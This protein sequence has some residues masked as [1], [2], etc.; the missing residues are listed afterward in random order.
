MIVPEA[1]T[2]DVPE[3]GQAAPFLLIT[4]DT[5]GDN[6]WSRPRVTGTRN[7]EFVP[8]FQELCERHHLRPTWLTNHEMISSAVFRTFAAD[9]IARDTAEIG[10]HLHAWDSPPLEP[11]TPDDRA[12]QP[13]LIEYPPETMRLKIRALTRELEEALGVK[14]VSHRAGRW[15]FD[16]RYAEML[17]EEGY[18]VDSS[19]T[20]RVSWTDTAGGLEGSGGSDY[21]AFPEDAYW[22]DLSDVSRAGS[23]ALLEVPMTILSLRSRAVRS[24]VDRL[25]HLDPTRHFVRRAANRLSPPL[26][27]LR[28]TGR[29]GLRLERVAR[30]VL[31]ER[32]RYA[33][34]MLHSS[35]LM[36]AGSPTFRDSRAIEQM[37][38][39][40]EQLFERIGQHFRP[41]TLSEFHDELVERRREE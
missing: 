5:E 30:R 26:D 7:A 3:T 4:I 23:S 34:L 36:P 15:A 12:R 19:V 29:N 2:A 20:P 13:Y 41:A 11:L 6:A 39:D 37:Y 32:R 40:L 24:V 21:T 31:K 14:M 1:I 9:V 10:M 22:V 35:E 16:E 27:W 17:L 8:R 33:Q 18:K 38:A 25:D 28:P